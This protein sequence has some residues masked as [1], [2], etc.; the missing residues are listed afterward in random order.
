MIPPM[1]RAAL[2]LAALLAACDDMPKAACEPTDTVEAIDLNNDGRPDVRKYIIK[3]R[4]VCRET[5]LDFDGDPD[6]IVVADAGRRVSWTGSDF[7][8]DGRCDHVEVRVDGVPKHV[9]LDLDHD[10]HPDKREPR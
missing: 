10:G 9:L 1:L 5:D 2:V 4:E 6:T 7:D 8:G 3:G